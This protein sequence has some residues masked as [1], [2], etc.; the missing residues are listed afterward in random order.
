MRALCYVALFFLSGLT[1]SQSENSVGPMLSVKE[2]MNSLITPTTA[3]IWGA[4]ELESDSEWQDIKN[5]AISVIGAGNLLAMGG[6]AQDELLAQE[7]EWQ[8]FNS[9]M[10]EAAREVIAAVNQKD[11]EALFMIGNDKLYPPCESCHQQ[12]QTR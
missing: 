2:I 12:Y 1:F 8:E 7:A 5:A 10:I 4:Y 9:Q 11:E 3:V 6:S